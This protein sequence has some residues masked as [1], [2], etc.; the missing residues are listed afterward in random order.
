MWITG[1]AEMRHQFAN[2]DVGNKTYVSDADKKKL[3]DTLNRTLKQ[4]IMKD[5]TLKLCI[6]IARF[7]IS[8]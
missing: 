7:H 2:A 1:Y 8:V 3:C 6:I 4:K 5:V